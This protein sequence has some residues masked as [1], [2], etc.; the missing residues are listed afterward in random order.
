MIVCRSLRRLLCRASC[1]LHMQGLLLILVFPGEGLAGGTDTV[2]GD[3]LCNYAEIFTDVA[4]IVALLTV[5]IFGVEMMVTKV[6]WGS[7]LVHLVG[8]AV[9]SSAAVIVE[10]LWLNSGSCI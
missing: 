8:A 4:E 3:A 1:L 7:A 5:C 9:V 6:T 2:I 10:L